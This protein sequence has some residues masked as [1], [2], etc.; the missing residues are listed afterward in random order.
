MSTTK[1]RVYFDG[2]DRQ[3]ITAYRNNFLAR[4]AE[5]DKRSI[6]FEGN[7]P[8]SLVILVGNGKT[9]EHLMN[10][11]GIMVMLSVNC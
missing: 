9:Y 7:V 4:M 5:Y 1:S 2:H 8:D 3:D 11:S 10:I 6:T